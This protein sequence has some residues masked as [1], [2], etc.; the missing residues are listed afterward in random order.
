MPLGALNF[1]SNAQG[2]AGHARLVAKLLMY[3]PFR[4][5]LRRVSFARPAINCRIHFRI[6]RVT[7]STA[8]HLFVIT[9]EIYSTCRSAFVS[10]ESKAAV[11]NKYCVAVNII[12]VGIARR[13]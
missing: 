8:L 12:N 4:N 6:H 7:S 2:T 9:A 3:R 5:P 10:S 13:S 1:K 11:I